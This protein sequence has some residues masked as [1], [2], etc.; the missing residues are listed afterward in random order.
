MNKFVAVS[1]V[2]V[3]MAIIDS[4][5]G[6]LGLWSVTGGDTQR[7][8][9]TGFEAFVMLMLL[10]NSV[11]IRRAIYADAALG[12]LRGVATLSTLSLLVCLGGDWV[13]FNIPQT[14][15]RHGAVIRHDYLADSVMFFAPG[16]ALL[17]A[18][19][20]VAFRQ[21]GRPLKPLVVSWVVAAGVG[22]VTLYS[23][24]LPGT[25][26]YVTAIT[27]GYSVVITA[28]GLTGA[29]LIWGFG[30]LNASAGIWWVGGGVI[31]ANLA[32]AVIGQFWIYGNGGE[33]FFPIAREVNWI[34]YVASQALVI[35]LPRV[36]AASRSSAR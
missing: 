1:V 31:L 14:Y 26:L 13:N 4:V 8:W 35:H 25:G 17:I 2:A 20:A 30:G 18:A 28:V 16:Y 23:M 19:V 15:F 21:A 7:L 32:D 29:M 24:H 3:A 10:A 11:A 33:G 36:V 12:D 27:G 22:V 9:I 6:M 5:G 34:M